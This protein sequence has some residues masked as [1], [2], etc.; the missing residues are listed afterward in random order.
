MSRKG[1]QR[2]NLVCIVCNIGNDNVNQKEQREEMR[3]DTR[4]NGREQSIQIDG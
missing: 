3:Q 1:N 2:I 4:P